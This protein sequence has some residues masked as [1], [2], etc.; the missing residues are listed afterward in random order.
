VNVSATGD[1][2]NG[3]GD[4]N[5]YNIGPNFNFTIADTE[6]PTGQFTFASGYPDC[7]SGNTLVSSLIANATGTFQCTFVDGLVPA[8]NNAVKVKVADSGAA[9]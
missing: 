4:L 7:G 1:G 3:A 5:P 6:T 8:V 9:E 2:H